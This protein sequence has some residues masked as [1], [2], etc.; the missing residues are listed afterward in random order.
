MPVGRPDFWYGQVLLFEQ[1]PTAGKTDAGPTSDWAHTHQENASAH[2]TK[3][4]SADIDHGAV[5]GLGDDDHTQYMPCNASRPFTAKIDMSNVN[6]F[7]KLHMTG[8]DEYLLAH[9]PS[10]NCNFGI[11]N[12]TDQFWTFY[13][14]NDGNMYVNGTV[15]GVDIAAHAASTSLHL[16][17]FVDRGDP[18]AFDWGL[19]GMTFDGAWHDLNMSSVVPAGAVA[20]LIHVL[21]RCNTAGRYINFRKNGISNDYNSATA[22][23]V[24]SSFE[25]PTDIVVA[26]DSNRYIEYYGPGSEVVLC[27]LTVRGWWK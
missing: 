1:L 14:D 12:N 2:H 16:P 9:L 8:Y 25:T 24:S 17:A 23:S 18:S 21:L 20:V 22:M 15:D 11:Y 19:A 3:T 13:F 5:T 7:M 10:V 4:V 6:P 26:C 27:G